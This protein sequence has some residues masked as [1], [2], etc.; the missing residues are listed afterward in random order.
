VQGR[1]LREA[2]P[3]RVPDPSGDLRPALH[4]LVDAGEV[5]AHA[6]R[7]ALDGG[8]HPQPV[9]EGRSQPADLAVDDSDRRCARAVRA[10]ALPLGQL[11]A[12]HR[13]GRGR[14]KFA[15][16]QD[17]RRPT[18]PR[19]AARDATSSA[20]DLPRLGAHRGGGA[21][22]SRGS[23]G[24]AR[25]RDAGRVAGRV[26]R[27]N[28]AA[29]GGG[30]VPLSGWSALLVRHAADGHEARGGSCRATQA[31][32]RQGGRRSWTSGCAPT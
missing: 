7:A 1:R 11:G 12:D 16:A 31:R 29:R 27:R 30:D 4:G 3:G 26:R 19:Q 8:S 18:E 10:D 24:E 5:P 13:E 2:H 14:P 17:R 20:H 15:T 22:R 32:P 21:P 9:G 28:A 23:P 6:W 25:L